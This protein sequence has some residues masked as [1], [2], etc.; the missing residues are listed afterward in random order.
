MK[1][2][3]LP[4]L[5]AA[6]SGAA[7]GEEV[8]QWAGADKDPHP[9]LYITA[10]DVAKLKQTRTDLAALAAT[11]DWNADGATEQVI[12]GILLAESPGAAK[13]AAA[14]AQKALDEVLA[15]IPDTT[16]KNVGPHAYA[17]PFGLGAGLADAALAA[18]SLT[19]EERAALLS[20]IA[21]I[22]YQMNDPKYWN[23]EAGKGSLCPNMY[24]SAAGYRLSM[25]ALIPSHPLAKQWF[26]GAL[27]ELTQE[28]ADWTDPA[29]GM[30]EC[31]HYSMVIFD[32][33]LG[34]FLIAR[35]AGA[36]DAGHVFDARLQKAIAWFGNISTPRD[37]R[38]G[39]FR[40]WPSI[41]HTYANERTSTFGVMACLWRDKDPAFAAQMEW[42]HRE[43]GSFGE[44]GILSYYPAFMGYR[45]FFRASGVAPKAPVWGSTCYPETGVQL[46][47]TLGS[48]RETTLY[49]IAGRN[50]SHYYNDSGSI[51]LWGKGRELLEE[52]S[53][54][55]PRSKDS[56]SVHSMPDQPATF[57]EERVMALHE[58]SAAADFDYVRGQRRGWQRQIAFVKDADPLGPNYFL[59]ADTFDAKSVPTVW[60]LF[61]AA[62]Q[63]TPTAT[64]VTV[65]G[66]DDV[67][68]DI[69]FLR[70]AGV[71]VDV[72]PN[73]IA[74]AVG[75]AGTLAAVLYPRLK[76]EKAPA[77]T[78]LA[79]G[80]GAK[81]VTAAGTDYV[82]LDPAPF[83]AKDGDVAFEGKVGVVKVRGGK[84]AKSVPGA[85]PVAPGWE[86]GDRELRMIRWK[87][88][89]YPPSPDE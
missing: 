23:P 18:K 28:L 50:H 82:F 86:G 59:L 65:V 87:G 32:Q 11:K 83:T 12:A 73:H 10:A 36:P 43:H 53:Y 76:T 7:G 17:R 26:A 41:G 68:L 27:A 1:R 62:T 89:Q 52:D 9:C 55:F 61:L 45:Q 8:L 60:R 46:R 39:G 64:G 4:L 71:K 69:V 38:G 14:A 33:W 42:L 31:P 34:A 56:R 77:I 20:R 24:T 67:D 37:A 48:D 54:Q 47:N 57:N 13:V 85:C 58:F 84:T 79:D 66:K 25:A 72:Q 2:L 49:L 88:P 15:R 29:G 40:R 51:T 70:P 16:V 5:V 3:L 78:P 19:P 30:I 80:R 21:R 75:A 74:V 81:V 44:P 35:N 22:C 63:I 6:P